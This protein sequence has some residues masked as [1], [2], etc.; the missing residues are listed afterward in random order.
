MD[1]AIAFLFVFSAFCLGGTLALAIHSKAFNLGRHSAWE[2]KNNAKPTDP[3]KLTPAK[4]VAPGPEGP[5][6]YSPKEPLA[7][8]GGPFD[9]VPVH[10]ETSL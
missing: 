5:P 3:A 7:S 6:I 4:V 10:V 8:A 2:D 1:Y 9:E